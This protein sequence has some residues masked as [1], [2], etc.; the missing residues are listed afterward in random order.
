MIVIQVHK[1]MLISF[2]S[3]LVQ[4]LFCSV[5]SVYFL[6]SGAYTILTTVWT[7]SSSW[8]SSTTSSEKSSG[9]LEQIHL[10]CPNQENEMKIIFIDSDVSGFIERDQTKTTR[11]KK[12]NVLSS[13]DGC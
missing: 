8:N 13:M 5:L 4:G 9:E 12:K 10:N 6:K 7:T 2:D 1:C 11:L 3:S